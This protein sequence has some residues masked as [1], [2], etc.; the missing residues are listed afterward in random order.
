MRT[1]GQVL[2]EEREK[3]LYTLDEVEKAT[4]IRKEL[5]QALEAGQYHKLPSST[6]VQGFIKNYSKF[7]GLDANKLLAVYRREFSE[8]K[9]PPRVMETWTNPLDKKRVHLTPTKALGIII[10][11][12]VATFFF[13]LWFEYRF[14][15]G[16]PFLEVT[17]PQDQ[18]STDTPFIVVEGKADPEA[19]VRINNQEIQVDL[20]G[21]F[22]QEIKL[23]DSLND[24][25]ITATGKS[26]K[27]ARVERSV[28]LKT[29]SN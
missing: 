7:L 3:K 22:A 19:K 21:R 8:K 27:V 18:M 12:L 16:A 5:L 11:G 4:K 2:K 9:N 6:F 20:S 29:T 26:G 25:V 28:Y 23:N 14:L 15:T 13:Y 24:I 10:L 1:V 17:H